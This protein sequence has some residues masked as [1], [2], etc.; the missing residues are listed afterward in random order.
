MWKLAEILEHVNFCIAR[1]YGKREYEP[2]SR[3]S[4]GGSR[5]GVVVF[6]IFSQ[7]CR[8]SLTG[9]LQPPLHGGGSRSCPIRSS[10]IRRWCSS[11]R[12]IVA[13]GAEPGYI[14]VQSPHLP[15]LVPSPTRRQEPAAAVVLARGARAHRRT[16]VCSWLALAAPKGDAI[17]RFAARHD[18]LL[19]V[20]LS[21]G[22]APLLVQF[23]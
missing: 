16:C 7:Y 10:A 13:E 1:L 12:A 15:F 22:L 5:S 20:W 23:R 18:I 9:L 21:L 2:L 19:F 17:L 11:A 8:W 6:P 4:T 3:S 14:G